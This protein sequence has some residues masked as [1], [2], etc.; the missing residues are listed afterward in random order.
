MLRLSWNLAAILLTAA[1][2][3]GC[4]DD[5]S[6][7]DDGSG[8]GGASGTPSSSSASGGGDGGAPDYSTAEGFCAADAAR[9][10]KCLEEPDDAAQCVAEWT[11]FEPTFVPD[12]LHALWQCIAERPCAGKSDDA[13]FDEVAEQMPDP[14][15][16]D[17]YLAA[18]GDKV[19][20]CAGAV[21]NDWCASPIKLLTTAAYAAIQDCLTTPCAETSA[22]LQSARG[23]CE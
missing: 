12:A 1:L 6:E 19:V 5:G 4:G 3:G 7:T 15:G 18:C 8:Q 13:C 20:E 16:F 17:D 21:S 9:S 2:L 23:D 22:C 10:E 14:E 11:C